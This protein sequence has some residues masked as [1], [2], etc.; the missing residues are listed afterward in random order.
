MEGAAKGLGIAALVVAI[1]SLLTPVVTLYVIWIALLAASVASFMGDRAF[2]I[3]TIVI[4]GINLV[5]LSP[6]TLAVLI[7]TAGGQAGSVSLAGITIV[8]FAAPVI[9][10]ALSAFGKAQS[11]S[12]D[13]PRRS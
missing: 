13:P 7:G 3:A 1:V 6:L 9:G 10:M 11:I 4:C 8:L 2:S 12:N 5:L